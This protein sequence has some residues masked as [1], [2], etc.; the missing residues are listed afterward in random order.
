MD[1]SYKLQLRKIIFKEDDPEK[2]CA[3]YPI[4]NYKSYSECDDDFVSKSIPTGLLP[5]WATNNLDMVTKSKFFPESAYFHSNYSALYEG[6]QPSNCP[7]PCTTYRV[8]SRQLIDEITTRNI[9]VFDISFNPNIHVL[10][11]WPIKFTFASFLS[12]VGGSMGFWLGV[13]VLQ[14]AQIGLRRISSFL[15]CLRREVID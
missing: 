1:R 10:T 15:S 8:E 5:I 6:F 7:L 2:S 12:E 14:M 3:N 9:S 11:H 4:K 13:G